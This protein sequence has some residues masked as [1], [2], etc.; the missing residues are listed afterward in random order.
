MSVHLSTS[1]RRAVRVAFLGKALKICILVIATWALPVRLEAQDTLPQPRQPDPFSWSFRAHG[2]GII[3]HSREL[4]DVSK[5][6]PYGFEITAQWLLHHPRHTRKLGLVSK[7]GFAAHYM[8]F[9]NPRVLGHAVSL[10]PYVEPLI[11]PWRP[12]YGSV[13]LGLGPVWLTRLYHAQDNPTNLFFSFPL[14]LWAMLNAHAH[15][16]FSPQWEASLGFNYNHIS[17]GGMRNPNKGMNFPT[18]NA[19]LSFS[20]KPARILRPEKNRDWKQQPRHQLY[21]L[22][23]GTVKNAEAT[24]AYPRTKPCWSAGLMLMAARRVG[25]FSRLSA[26]TEWVR[27]GYA[28]EIMAREGISKSPWKGG[29]LLGHELV[30]GQVSFATHFGTYVFNPSGDF[31]PVYQRYGLYYRWGRHL[32]LGSSLKAH[33]HVADVFDVRAGWVW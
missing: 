6:N 9:D 32:L 22:A 19:G 20:P 3:A 5:S 17:N 4:V 18:L 29:L 21:A 1:P 23:I 15:Y 31:D 2:G 11:R 16:R 14:S 28:D 27:D 8:N 12:L 7:R 13:R 33:R 30:V 25:R 26:G 10:V 24:V